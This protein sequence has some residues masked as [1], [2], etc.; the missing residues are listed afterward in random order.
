MLPSSPN[1]V[2]LLNRRQ[3]PPSATHPPPPLNPPQ[4]EA[5]Q[6]TVD[7]EARA[8][9]E[10]LEQQLGALEQAKQRVATVDVGAAAGAEAA[11]PA[12]ASAAQ[13]SGNPDAAVVLQQMDG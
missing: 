3:A 4:L 10:L 9:L 7:A 12:A 2:A 11:S 5:A 6:G 1:S 8:H 13:G